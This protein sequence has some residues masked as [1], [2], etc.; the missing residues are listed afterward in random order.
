MMGLLAVTSV[1]A[2]NAEAGD[3]SVGGQMAFASRHSQFGLGAQVQIEPVRNFRFAPEFLY[4][5]ENNHVKGYNANINLHYVI[6]TGYTTAI[7]P[8]AGFSFAHF[9]Y[10]DYGVGYDEERYGA[11]VGCG[12]EYCI[13]NNLR[14]YTEERFQIL[15]NHNQSVTCLGLKYT[16]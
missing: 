16:F 7:Y 10:D 5:F 6:S 2:A 1:L 3:I 14:F 9:D 13:N 11:N 15:K 4:F 12:F 8:L